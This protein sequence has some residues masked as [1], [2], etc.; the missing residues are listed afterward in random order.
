VINMHNQPLNNSI[1]KNLCQVKQETHMNKKKL[2][3]NLVQPLWLDL[4]QERIDQVQL[5]SVGY[6]WKQLIIRRRFSRMI[7]EDMK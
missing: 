7:L 5:L 1:L 6:L 2:N 3:I 4:D